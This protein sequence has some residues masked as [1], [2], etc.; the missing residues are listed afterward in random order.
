MDESQIDELGNKMRD[1]YADVASE[2]PMPANAAS[3]HPSR[4]LRKSRTFAGANTRKRVAK[5]SD[6]SSIVSRHPMASLLIAMGIG[7]LCARL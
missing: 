5:P 3:K 4:R 1:V 7:Y 6:I 2:A